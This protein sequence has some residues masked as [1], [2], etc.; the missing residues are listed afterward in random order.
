VVDGGQA[1][2][3]EAPARREKTARAGKFRRRPERRTGTW[4]GR[5]NGRWWRRKFWGNRERPKMLS[6]MLWLVSPS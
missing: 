3:R 5:R 2:F 4:T 1:V 6:P